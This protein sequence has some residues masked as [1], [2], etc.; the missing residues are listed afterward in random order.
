M[1]K[2]FLKLSLLGGCVLGIIGI[3]GWLLVKQVIV[4]HTAQKAEAIIEQAIKAQP[5]S[6]DD[7]KL[8][9]IAREV[10]QNFKHKDPGQV[11]LLRLRPYLTN[12]R[13]PSFLRLPD[14][15]IETI[16]QTGLCDNASRMLSFIVGQ[17]GYD[18]VQWNMVLPQKGHSALLVTMP[19]Q[20]RVL[21]DPFYGFVTTDADGHLIHPDK[22]YEL[23]QKG[24]SFDD[25]F[26][27]LGE[28]SDSR[29]Y[30]SFQKVSMAAQGDDLILEATLPLL[31]GKELLLGSVDGKQNDVKAATMEHDMTP[32]WNYAG[33]KYNREWV[34]ILK[35][36]QPVR[37]VITLVSQVEEGILTATPAPIV[38]G[39]TMTWDLKKGE[40]VTFRDGLAKVS[41]KR[42]NSYIDVDQIAVYPLQGE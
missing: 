5:I 11:F 25:I 31:N 39:N 35:T 33:H 29:F 8:I 32:Y 19:D 22:A 2:K 7:E 30:K 18:S 40:Q 21:V 38:N 4:S 28:D 42:L 1:I 36:R 23:L 17:M 9:A 6:T 3:A 20:R 16:L 26:I 41:L 12:H 14:G 24:Q 15:V 34:R 10:F 13:L 27:S 37:L